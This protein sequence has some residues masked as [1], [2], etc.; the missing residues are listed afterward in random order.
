MG[1][2][3]PDQGSNWQT[4]HWKLNT[5]ALDHQGSPM[6]YVL[7]LMDYIQILPQSFIGHVNTFVPQFPHF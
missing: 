6:K 1:S 7:T 2:E 5:Q 3:L 4:L